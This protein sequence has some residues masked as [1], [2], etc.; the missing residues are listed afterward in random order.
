MSTVGTKRPTTTGLM[1]LPPGAGPKS[2]GPMVRAGATTTTSNPGR[3]R[4]SAGHA[5]PRAGGSTSERGRIPLVQAFD[6]VVV[7]EMPPAGYQ[8]LVHDSA[9]VRNSRK[10][11]QGKQ[12][13]RA[14]QWR[15][16]RVT[17]PPHASL[18]HGTAAT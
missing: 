6:H 5:S 13:R 17:S 7:E 2:S 10:R 3:E 12:L 8:H 16:P 14:R 18:I 4:G 15:G 9:P 11:G 1:R